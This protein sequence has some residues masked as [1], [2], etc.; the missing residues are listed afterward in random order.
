LKLFS[1]SGRARITSKR[2]AL[3]VAV[4]AATVAGFVGCGDDTGSGTG[5]SGAGVPQFEL[6]PAAG[7]V[8]LL[9]TSQMR[10]SVEYLLGSDAAAVLDLWQD[11]QIHG[12]E[13]IAAAQLALSATNV[14]T[15]ESVTGASIDR[16]LEDPSHIARFAPCVMND[17]ST[18][19]Y[20]EV[21]EKFGRVAWRRSLDADEKARLAAI[22]QAGQQWGAGDFDAGLH[23]ELSA[24]LQS[25]NFLYIAELGEG[26]SSTRK[27]TAN[28][29]ASRMSFFLV[30]RTP[31]VELL[32]AA[33]GGDLDTDDGIREQAHRML[34]LPEA[35][36]AVDRFYSELY[37]IRDLSNVSKDA[38]LYPEWNASLAKSMQ[39]ELLRSI[40]DLVWT[41]NADF[42]ELFNS[43]ETFVDSNLALL[44]GV[45]SPGVGWKK[46]TLPDGQGRGGLLSKP[47]YLARF[48]HPDRTSPTRRGRFFWE[49][50]LCVEIGDPPPGVI[51]TIPPDDPNKPQTMRE[52]LAVHKE[53]GSCSSCHT[54]LDGVGL[55][56]EHFDS[57]GR[58]R[59]TD[60][61]LEIITADSNPDLG[62]YA[63][64]A[65]L[66]QIL[67][68]DDQAANCMVQNFW[69]QSMGH[70]ETDGE[71]D[72]IALLDKSFS[73]SGYR[74]QDL[75]VE[76]CAN[77]AFRNVDA[78]K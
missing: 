13:S 17:P 26:D 2:L 75:M 9:T 54:R 51:T 52:K 35:R 78:P 56:M 53:N 67:H 32:D 38:T 19:C 33:D 66:G 15:L 68:D 73:A 40:Q 61:G 71:T 8:R 60:R 64:P 62:D 41:R 74:V 3:A 59:E 4:G 6:Q 5:G 37:L 70:V 34:Q 58:Y 65:D 39:E 36:R 11:Q 42:R 46:V 18:A 50:L 31:D 55:T 77:P 57:V 23:Y 22:G 25:P 16:S 76:L 29:L 7:G 47:G 1:Q 30:H 72:S 43:N 14:D 21:A 10:Y 63:S 49:K 48:A 27:L 45:A 28:E 69:R 20:D 12:F 44:Y 24:I